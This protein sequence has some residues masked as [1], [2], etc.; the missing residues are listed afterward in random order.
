MTEKVEGAVIG[1]PTLYK[2]EYCE[3]IIEYFNRDPIETVKIEKMD[4]SGECYDP[5]KFKMVREPCQCPTFEYFS[6]KIG[7]TRQT[8][9]SWCK[10][11][12]E[13]LT[14]YE[15][16]RAYQAN[17]MLVNGMSGAYNAG[18]TGLSM[19]NM[20]GWKDKSEVENHHTVNQMAPVSLNNKQ[21]DFDIGDKLEDKGD[22]E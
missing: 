4:E 21:L 16:A 3:L 12:P 6:A 8:V 7:V 22:E 10:T 14:A 15:T 11:Y 2:P 18:F 1:R 5:P 9:S 19:K 17:I 20:H 13:F